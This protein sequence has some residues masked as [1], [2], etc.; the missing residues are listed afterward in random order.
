MYVSRTDHL[1]LEN[2]L[3][4][5]SS[6]R[7]TSPTPSFSQLPKVLCIWLKTYEIFLVRKRKGREMII[8]RLSFATYGENCRKSQPTKMQLWNPALSLD[9][10]DTKSS[11]NIEEDGGMIID[12]NV[13]QFILG[14]SCWWDITGRASVVS[15]R[16]N[17]TAKSLISWLFFLSAP[18]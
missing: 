17:L 10:S 13:I 7:G 3:A 5:S 16:H 4:C 15:R 11:R 1:V 9:P 12:V 8:Q 18:P 14:W 2:R 6:E